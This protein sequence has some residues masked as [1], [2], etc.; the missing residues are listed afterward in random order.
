MSQETFSLVKERL[1]LVN[2]NLRTE[3]HGDQRES[4]IDIAFEFDSA[5]NLL[6][7]LHPDLRAI[8]YRADATKDAVTPDHMPHLRLPLLGPVSWDVEIPRTR[9]RVHD[10]DDESHDVLLGGGRTNKFKLTMKE[11]GT[12]NWKFRVQFSKPD[13]DM[14]ARLMRVLNQK[15]PVSLE[16][17]DE[18]E[19]GDNFEQVEQLSLT[20]KGPSEARQKLESLFDKPPTDMA[21]ADGTDTVTVE[22]VHNGSVDAP[23]DGDVV[24]ATFIPDPEQVETESVSIVTPIKGKRGAGKK[25]DPVSIE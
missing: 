14:V 25:K 24:D 21:I 4:A 3:M 20:G 2:L 6:F 1:L 13:E 23:A 17:V 12:V 5:N 15:V 9:L 16:C 19:K 8:F 7:K 10:V 18:E 22:S 11:G